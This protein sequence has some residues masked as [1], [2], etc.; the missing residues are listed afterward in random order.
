MATVLLIGISPCI[1]YGQQ[2]LTFS[3]VK[4]TASNFF[5][6]RA[7]ITLSGT[8]RA[9]TDVTG[10]KIWLT[11]NGTPIY[12]S[13]P[14]P[15]D[16]SSPYTYLGGHLL[17][18]LSA[19]TTRNFRFT[20]NFVRVSASSRCGLRY[21]H[22]V[23]RNP[24]PPATPVAT[25]LEIVSGDGQSA[26]VNQQLAS[27]LVVRV[28]DQNGDPM[29]GVPV[30]FSVSPS[31]QVTKGTEGLIF[32]QMDL[33]FLFPDTPEEPGDQ[34][35]DP[36]MDLGILFSDTPEGR[37]SP[38]H[39]TTGA[40]GQAQTRLTLG[41]TAGTY[42]VTARASGITQSVTF[43]ATA[44]VPTVSIPP[45][46]PIYW[47]DVNTDKIQRVNSNSSN[48]E[49]LVTGLPGPQGVAL[50]VAGGKM[51]WTDA[52]TDKIQRA[53]LDGS[54][55]QDLVT[56]G[57]N[58]PSGI[59][60][61]VA[62]GKM[63]WMDWGTDK[64]QRANLDGSNIQDLITHGLV[65]PG[66]IALDV[67]GGKMYWTDEGTDKIQR[68]N[69]DGSNIED[70]ITGLP[71]PWG[72]ALDIAGGKMYWTDWISGG[73]QRA[74]LDGSNVENLIAT[75][76]DSSLD[77]ALDVA[78]G[79]MYWAHA[80]YNPSTRTYSNGKI[81]RANLNGTAVQDLVTGLSYPEGIAL[82]IPQS[83]AT[84][85]FSPSVVANQTFTVGTPASLSL[86]IATGG[87]APY[88][89]TLS[90][91]PAGLQF[92]TTTRLLSGTP[93]TV[94]TTSATYTVTDAA[95]MSAELTFTIEVTADVTLDVN[96]DGQVT[97]TDLAIVALFYGIQVPDGVDLA[98]D[99][100]AD[101]TVNILDLTAVAQAID[102]AGNNSALSI[103]DMA[104]VLE[105]T[106]GI[107]AIPEAPATLRFST[108]QQALFTGVAYR[109]V[110]A[111]LEAA[112]HL[113]TDDIRL[114][115]WM[116]LLK[117][118]LHRLTE[119]RE[120]PETTALLPNYPNPFNPETWIP[121]QLA[122]PADVTLRI[123]AVDG[124][125][126][127]TLTLGHHPAGI[128]QSRSRA[129]YWDGRNAVGEP[130]ASGLYFYTLTAG[131]FTATRKMLIRK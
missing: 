66:H 24:P 38:S 19:G 98:A 106:A 103:D 33:G 15:R 26:P 75:G 86:P 28:R 84:I 62:S 77:I 89:Y 47:T 115:K 30:S 100:N 54:N 20:E 59:A 97:V 107:E 88:T 10:L 126:V 102:A 22:L 116:P 13:G 40:N 7:D 79:K 80:D 110:A 65:S 2:A 92:D 29:S 23:R 111:A 81:Q 50:D 82:G 70:L 9:N 68:A 118:L 128:Y 35:D 73:I 130:V 67:V 96:G 6:G 17:G 93:T 78:G 123:Y 69:L 104:A 31:G 108:S 85:T 5:A 124:Q 57:L 43:T 91:I 87:T 14:A 95:N 46:L 11:I 117:E 16:P 125:V 3:N 34:G 101:G 44:T 21:E 129:A 114:G 45:P 76:L 18:N 74:N 52:G 25:T 55:I 113:A 122:A 112:K 61:N 48:V 53:N 72:I 56:T 120:I 64:I 90:P 39:A 127:R 131:D 109:N 105:A 58:T 51:Y 119:M 60:L 83:S 49:D 94:G 37:V 42:T 12:A 32:N 1:S 41:S 4:C 63:Y 121:Y 36:Q 8:V 71:G 27:P 99:V